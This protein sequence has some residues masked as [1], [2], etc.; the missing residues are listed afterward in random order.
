MYT[1][2]YRER[3]NETLTF[4]L[5]YLTFSKIS[6]IIYI[7]NEGE[8]EM[9]CKEATD[10]FES[11][12]KEDENFSGKQKT[13]A[14]KIAIALVKQQINLLEIEKQKLEFQQATQQ[15]TYE[16]RLKLMEDTWEWN[17]LPFSPIWPYY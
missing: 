11:M 14:L 12:M 16:Q 6:A 2:R 13:A 10:I 8:N 3:E 5:F 1:C 9:T 15:S 17:G 7:E 4:S